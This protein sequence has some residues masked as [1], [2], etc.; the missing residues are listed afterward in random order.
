MIEI[1]KRYKVDKHKFTETLDKLDIIAEETITSFFYLNGDKN[2][3]VRIRDKQLEIT[4]KF[5]QN[6]L[7]KELTFVHKEND[8]A[9]ALNFMLSLGFNKGLYTNKTRYKASYKDLSIELDKYITPELYVIEVEFTSNN[10]VQLDLVY[11]EIDL[12]AKGLKIEDYIIKNMLKLKKELKE[13][14]SFE[15]ASNNDILKFINH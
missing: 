6:G 15:F 2:V 11:S 9:K 1:E 12:V 8:L 10:N 14:S 4:S 3:Q 5:S 7:P 13:K